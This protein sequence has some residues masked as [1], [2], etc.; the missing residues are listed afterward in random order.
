MK[1]IFI[2]LLLALL[3]FVPFSN[4][5]SAQVQ[6][7]KGT[8][9]WVT[10]MNNIDTTQHE[11]TLS[12]FAT[13]VYPCVA[14]ITNP[15][16]GWSQ[17]LTINPGTTNRIFIPLQQAYTTTSGQ[18]TNTG[19]HVT[20]SDSISLY[21][22]TQGY[23]NLDY[24]NILPT[25]L[26]NSQYMIQTYP[27]DR[28]SSEFSIVAAEDS[29]VVSIF[30]K[31]NTIDGHHNGQTYT[32]S[33]PNAGQV[34]QVQSTVPGDLSGTRIVAANGKK[35]AVFNGDAC[36]YIPNYTIGPSCDHVVEQA[37]PTVYWGKNF[38][39]AASNG[40][41]CDYIRI[42]SLN[43]NCEVLVNG[44][45]VS[46]LNSS[47][48]YEYLMS[49][50]SAIDY[51]QTS[52][53]AMVYIYF[54]SLNGNGAGDPSMTT[55]IPIEQ[56]LSE[57]RFPTIGTIN[58]TSHWMNLICETSSVPD[59][60]VDGNG[61]SSYF[62]SI[63]NAPGYAYYRCSL[64]EGIH[65]VIDTGETGFIAYMYG[66]GQRVSYGYALGFAGRNLF[67]PVAL[68]KVNGTNV[69]SY[70]NGVDVCI[71]KNTPFQVVSDGTIDSVLW[72]FGDG[73]VSSD[74]PVSHRYDSVGDYSVCAIVKYG[75]FIEDTVVFV[76]TLCTEMHVHP[77]YL[78]ERF[79]TCIQAN[80]PVFYHGYYLYSDVIGDTMPFFTTYGCDSTEIYHLKV[81]Y[82]DTV[83]IDTIVC[84]TLLPLE[85]HGIK[86]YCDS[87]VQITYTN[88]HGADSIVFLS[89]FTINCPRRIGPPSPAFD[90]TALW[91]PNVFTPNLS[92]NNVFQ[93][94]SHDIVKAV[95][96]IFNR[97]GNY[98]NKFNGLTQWWDGTD[99]R[100]HPCQQGVYVYKVYY[101]TRL[102][103]LEKKV[104]VG[105]VT[106]LR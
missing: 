38:I 28:Y 70:P 8:D 7:T 15:N 77:D 71:H 26:L 6:S 20:A 66:F 62:N 53:P 5:L 103:P 35:I 11:Q 33:I 54:P 59:I 60:L 48:T 79:D 24:A 52:E 19:L 31:G 85:W 55:I 32:V 42:T 57:I 87:T 44:V 37:W 69:A 96:Y 75:R 105:T 93:L 65:S 30:L 13:S 106:L 25:P 102:S 101:Q 94:Y 97:W 72:D 2:Y 61:V 80:L 10:F 83:W 27:A 99:H 16:T 86:F 92:E 73:T 22:I 36:V 78:S 81:W 104:A 98:V 23:P 100:G 82:N 18:L 58:I 88:Q 39:A 4:H 29:T 74:N 34:F 50:T 41:R 67:N 12:M 21:T 64:T 63:T 40:P 1:N 17:T 76:D 84:D 14:T 45:V 3:M 43:D 56:R 9:F 68:L 49:S 95:V 89:L 46:H 51:I 47:D 90:S 91:I